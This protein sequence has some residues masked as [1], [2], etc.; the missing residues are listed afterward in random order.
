MTGQMTPQGPGGGLAAGGGGPRARRR[1]LVTVGAVCAC[2][3]VLVG[4]AAGAGEDTPE[5]VTQVK[6]VTRVRT[7]KVPV[8]KVK[9]VTTVRRIVRTQTVTQQ[10]AAPVQSAGA[11]AS[12]GGSGAADYAGLNCSEIGHSFTVAPGSDPEH[13]ADNDGV[14]CESY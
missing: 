9:T 1:Q 4:V 2:L 11:E 8:V 7:E 6:T 3:G 12:A 5:P 10:V 14:A 13:D